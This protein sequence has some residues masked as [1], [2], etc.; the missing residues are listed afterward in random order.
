MI[1][2]RAVQTCG[3]VSGFNIFGL[4]WTVCLHKIQKMTLPP[5]MP[6]GMLVGSP[7]LPAGEVDG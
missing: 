1:S 3:S 4:F 6:D 2:G 7:T 5:S